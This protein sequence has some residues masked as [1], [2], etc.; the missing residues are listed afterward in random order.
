MTMTQQKQAVAL[1]NNAAELLGA[2]VSKHYTLNST[3][4]Q[5][6]KYILEYPITSYED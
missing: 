2:T 4:K 1:I 3:G 6:C 5:T